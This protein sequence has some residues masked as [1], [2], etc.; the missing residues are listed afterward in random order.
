MIMVHG[1]HGLRKRIATARLQSTC[2]RAVTFPGAT[3]H[4]GLLH[5]LAVGV[6]LLAAVE[7]GRHGCRAADRDR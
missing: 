4:V 2:E 1:W 7:A 6:A 3:W 5:A